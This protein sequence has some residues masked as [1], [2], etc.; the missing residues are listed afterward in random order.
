[1]LDKQARPLVSRDLE[2]LI[3]STSVLSVDFI[4]LVRGVADNV[5]SAGARVKI[6][7]LH[8]PLQ[9]KLGLEALREDGPLVLRSSVRS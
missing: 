6:S 3:A 5:G 1:M 7:V 2:H 8:E 9:T 4:G